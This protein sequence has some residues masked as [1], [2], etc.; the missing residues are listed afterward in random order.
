[1]AQDR[2]ATHL[3]EDL[4]RELFGLVRTEREIRREIGARILSGESVIDLRALRFENME[5]QE[6]L[7]AAVGLLDASST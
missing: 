1:M 5:T 2:E 7:S 3:A 4:R 6:D